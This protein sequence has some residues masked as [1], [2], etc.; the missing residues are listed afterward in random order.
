MIIG[1]DRPPSLG[2]DVVTF[3][4]MPESLVAHL[5]YEQQMHVTYEYG[6]DRTLAKRHKLVDSATQ[7]MVAD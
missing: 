4:D 3:E 6:G 1:G 5:E 7:V 2:G